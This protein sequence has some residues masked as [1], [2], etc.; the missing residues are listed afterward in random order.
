MFAAEYERLP[1]DARG[2][3][4]YDG[5]YMN[6]SDGTEE[7]AGF[8]AKMLSHDF[9]TRDVFN[10]NFFKVNISQEFSL[11]FLYLTLTLSLSLSEYSSPFYSSCTLSNSTI[12]FITLSFYKYKKLL[13]LLKI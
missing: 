10:N 5:Q 9:T 11:S 7:V 3:L 2:W 4:E 13:L 1:K 8:Y 6:L 12:F